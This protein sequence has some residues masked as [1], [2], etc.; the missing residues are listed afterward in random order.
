VRGRGLL[1]AIDLAVSAKTVALA[2]EARGYL[3]NAVQ[4]RSLRFA[5]PFIITHEEL[6]GFL[7]ALEEILRQG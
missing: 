5:P 1:I 2:A 7:S 3:V 4:E 6:T